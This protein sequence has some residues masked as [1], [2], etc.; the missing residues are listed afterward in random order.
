MHILLG[1]GERG[2]DHEGRM[3]PG[4]MADAALNLTDNRNENR[5]QRTG[6]KW[7]I[8]S[9][10]YAMEGQKAIGQSRCPTLTVTDIYQVYICIYI[11]IYTGDDNATR[12]VASPF[13]WTAN[14]YFDLIRK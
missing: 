11:Y 7:Y 3:T 10:Y 9:G 5:M 14:T 2:L 12:L 1:S 4:K 13:G 6:R 8:S